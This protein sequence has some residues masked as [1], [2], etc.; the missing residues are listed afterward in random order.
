LAA[1]ANTYQETIQSYS[2]TV[3][4]GDSIAGVRQM[5]EDE[6]ADAQILYR[7]RF[8]ASC[9]SDQKKEKALNVGSNEIE[10]RCR[11]VLFCH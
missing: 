6:P 10:C 8:F 4:K 2:E 3:R 5:Q 11:E 9:P 7:V 1:I